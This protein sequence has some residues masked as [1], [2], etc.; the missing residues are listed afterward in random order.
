[1]SSSPSLTET[2]PDYILRR[3][4]EELEEGQKPL[5]VIETEITELAGHINAANARLL[6]LIA[7]F[8]RRQGWADWG[9]RSAAH[10]LMWRCGLS[11]SAARDHVRVA[12]CLGAIPKITASFAK[13]A[14]SFSQVRALSRV[15]NEKN[16]DALLMWARHG[17]AAQIERMV[18]GYRQAKRI[19]EA[20]DARKV[21][22]SRYLRH[23]VDD[24]GSVVITAR[25]SPEEGALVLR[26]LEAAENAIPSAS[27]EAPEAQLEDDLV[28]EAAGPLAESHMNENDRSAAAR[29]LELQ[30]ATP[31]GRRAAD[32]LVVMA[33]T[34]I[35]AGPQPRSG[36]DRSSV[37]VHVDLDALV[38]DGGDMCEVEGIA[39]IPPETARM[40]SCDASVVAM[41]E[42]DGE[43]L[44]VGRKRRTLS[45]A[46]KRALE[47][48]D[49]CCQFPGCTNARF[50]DAHH[51]EHW[52][53]GGSTELSNL[54]LLCR[55]HHTFVHAHGYTIAPRVLGGFDFVR[56]D[57]TLVGVSA[58]TPRGPGIVERN[59]AVGLEIEPDTCVTEWCGDRM[60]YD[61]AVSHLLRSDENVSA[62][63]FDDVDDGS[64]EHRT[65][66]PGW[67]PL[68]LGDWTG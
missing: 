32:A 52:A 53:H 5:E 4:Y 37:V 43:I 8:D 33:E 28:K 45:S 38:S 57:G 17:T 50:V 26:A 19:E 1:M 59:I 49:R 2:A 51:I 21:H 10:W 60:D 20:D 40:L 11:S 3:P 18:R 12:R 35:E 44:S 13:G 39:A 61:D 27:A 36:G 55:Y 67:N 48:R 23:R 14:L 9:C 65:R 66:E 54:M 22:A 63:T 24:D 30:E 25:L 31:S 15:A 47:A 7:D 68:E 42:R 34:V 46:I 41:Y 29:L 56:P 64:D 62:E 58:E 6:L 16:E